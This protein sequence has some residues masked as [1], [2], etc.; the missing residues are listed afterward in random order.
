LKAYTTPGGKFRVE[1]K[2]FLDF[3]KQFGMPIPEELLEA[4][5]TI[6]IVD[7][8][9]VVVNLISSALQTRFGEVI[10]LDTAGDGFTACIKAGHVVP[11]LLM[12]DV[13]MPGMDGHAVVEKLR[14]APETARAKILSVSGFLDEEARSRFTE[15]GVNDFLDKPFSNKQLIEAV[16]S[17]INSPI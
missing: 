15:A 13:N 14:A 1:S 10:K 6:L 4:S 12:P 9:P 17:L 7:D 16:E 2:D 8:E 11:A 5:I 3:L